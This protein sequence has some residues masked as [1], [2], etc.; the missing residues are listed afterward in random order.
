MRIKYL[1][2]NA[3]DIWRGYALPE[4]GMK[5]SYNGFKYEFKNG[6]SHTSKN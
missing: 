6:V 3:A 4:R 5:F 2:S 1:V